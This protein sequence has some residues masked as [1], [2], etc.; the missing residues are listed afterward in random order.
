LEN[1][2]GQLASEFSITLKQFHK[3]SSRVDQLSEINRDILI[4]RRNTNCISCAKGMEEKYEPMKQVTGAD[5]KLYFSQG[6]G[7]REGSGSPGRNG[8]LN[9]TNH[10]ILEELANAESNWL[11]NGVINHS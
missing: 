11:R 6:R 9:N 4:G 10:S 7:E 8:G 5:G 2:F 3:M 1:H